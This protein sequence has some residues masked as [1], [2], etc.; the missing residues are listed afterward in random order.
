V[1]KHTIVTSWTEEGY[2]KYGRDFIR[3]FQEHWPEGT[4]LIVFYE[5]TNLRHDWRPI[6]EVPNLANWMRVIAPFQVMHGAVFNQYDIMMDAR[7][8][9][10]IFMQ[11]AVLRQ[12]KGKVFW[13]DGDVITHSKVPQTFLDEMLP[14]DKLCCYLGRGDWYDSETGFIGFNYDHPD[15][16]HFLK[17][18]ENCLFS[19]VVFA[20]PRW[21]DMQTFDWSR[22]ALVANKPH[23]AS[24]FV[25]LAKDLPRGCMHPFINSRVGAYM[26]HLKGA[27]KGGT[28]RREDLEVERTE[29]Y[30]QAI[31]NGS[32]EAKTA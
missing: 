27:R 1:T 12:R 30:W 8:N 22:T 9:R 32:P 13:I 31:I 25:D 14:D 21:W 24:A 11:N 5:G 29:P 16:E 26:D 3:T 2:Q 18:E 17:V 4:K 20:L 19:G 6:T 10:V 23:L 15:C 7:T 28:S